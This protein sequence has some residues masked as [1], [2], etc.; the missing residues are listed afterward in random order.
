MTILRIEDLSTF[1]DIEEY[2]YQV[3]TDNPLYYKA[4]KY[5]RY[6]VIIELAHFPKSA[7]VRDF[8]K[9]LNLYK[10]VG[11]IYAID[12]LT[13]R[14]Y[15]TVLWKEVVNRLEEFGMDHNGIT[16][17]KKRIIRDLS[18]PIPFNGN[19]YACCRL[20]KDCEIYKHCGK[21]DEAGSSYDKLYNAKD[22]ATAIKY[23]REI[24]DAW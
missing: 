8:I 21:C 9:A 4:L 22:K 2:K 12:L 16:H 14:Y 10:S 18:L 23:A 3:K 17:M 19:C 15:H 11:S 5:K 13:N 20:C 24:R 1:E 7:I 6:D